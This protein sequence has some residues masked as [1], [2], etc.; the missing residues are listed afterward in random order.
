MLRKI[1]SHNLKRLRR[2]KGLTQEEAAELCN[3]SPR[4]WRKLEQTQAAATIDVLEKIIN[5]LEGDIQD[6]FREETQNDSAR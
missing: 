5:G 3:I 1:L 2:V 4:Y 6:L